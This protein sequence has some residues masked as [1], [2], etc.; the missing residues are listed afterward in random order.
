[1]IEVKSDDTRITFGTSVT[2]PGLYD[3]ATA[4][5][6]NDHFNF[7]LWYVWG[8]QTNG[9]NKLFQ[10]S[11]SDEY[12][13]IDVRHGTPD[14]RVRFRW[15]SDGGAQVRTANCIL[16]ETP[17]EG[18]LLLIGGTI[19]NRDGQNSQQEIWCKWM[20]TDG[21]VYEE[22]TSNTTNINTALRDP[23]TDGPSVSRALIIGSN[24]D[25]TTAT[26]K[27]MGI[28]FFTTPFETGELSFTDLQNVWAS[29]RVDAIWNFPLNDSASD[30][31]ETATGVLASRSNEAI[32][33]Y[34]A[35][36]KPNRKSVGD[37]IADGD[38]LLR[39]LSSDGTPSFQEDETITLSATTAPTYLSPYADSDTSDFFVRKLPQ[40]NA[41]GDTV[42]GNAPLSARVARDTYAENVRVLWAANS[43]G[44]QYES[45]TN[46]GYP[47]AYW[48]G[49]ANLKE[50]YLAGLL[51]QRIELGTGSE[52]RRRPGFD[53]GDNAVYTDG[54]VVESSSATNWARFGS[55]S[56]TNGSGPGIVGLLKGDLAT[57]CMRW[58]PDFPGLATYDRSLTIRV[59]ILG[60][61]S[62]ENGTSARMYANTH[63]Q[64]GGAGTDDGGS[65]VN[66]ELGGSATAYDV[67]ATFTSSTANGLVLTGD[68]TSDFP[69]GAA[70]CW[71][72]GTNWDINVVASSIY[73]GTTATAIAFEQDWGGG[74]GIG[75]TDTVYISTEG[76][77]VYTQDIT[78]DAVSSGTWRGVTIQQLT[79]GTADTNP[80]IVVLGMDA[81]T[82]DVPGL[83][84]GPLGWGGNNYESQIDESWDQ[85]PRKL[86]EA[87][88]PDCLWFNYANNREGGGAPDPDPMFGNYITEMAAGAP[89]AEKV[90]I[91]DVMQMT[92]VD[93]SDWP[94]G[95]SWGVWA[96]GAAKDGDVDLFLNIVEDEGIGTAAEQYADGQREDSGHHSTRGMLAIARAVTAGLKQFATGGGRSPIRFRT[97][98]RN[99]TTY[100]GTPQ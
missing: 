91:S 32:F 82:E 37:D 44:V 45:D 72:D 46:D 89:L 86:T 5:G 26:G 87:M 93:G 84:I 40:R 50:D 22:T 58:D 52:N 30:Y 68:R 11:D 42:R 90:I 39:W 25:N 59:Y 78:F 33:L 47:H 57:I 2:L 38:N 66:K 24:S 12:W 54:T 27:V 34:G 92:D 28:C 61:Y 56:D 71:F 7:L 73:N 17:N 98:S 48:A 49:M 10:T 80:P 77:Y 20:D 65:V 36:T 9:N 3:A 13:G 6:T 35:A 23:D 62:N 21:T 81:W 76:L 94:D 96:E 8:D 16:S 95:D 53:V 88:Q 51:N 43:R 99:N 1:V 67:T 64:Q 18:A 63:T 55:S 74:S 14:V 29:N 100:R 83:V 4:S 31:S 97:N 60:G 41:D 79:G 70:V 69:S 85:W 15:S 19:R 75:S